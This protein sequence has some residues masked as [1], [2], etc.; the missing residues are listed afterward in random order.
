MPIE[1]QK[2]KI[3]IVVGTDQNPAEFIKA[4]GKRIGCEIHKI[5]QSVWNKEELPEE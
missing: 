1:K 4:G 5:I 2:K 3:K